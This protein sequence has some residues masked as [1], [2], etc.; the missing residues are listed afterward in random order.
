MEKKVFYFNITYRCNER[1]VFCGADSQAGSKEA[2]AYR[3]KD[4]SMQEFMKSLRDIGVSENDDIRI[5]GGEPSLHPNF[6]EI[7]AGAGESGSSVWVSTTASYFANPNH[8]GRL[9]EKHRCLFDVRLYAHRPDLHDELTRTPG[10]FSRTVKGLRNLIALRKEQQF[11]YTVGVRLLLA[12]QTLPYLAETALFAIHELKMD[13][14]CVIMLIESESTHRSSA[15][16]P[17]LRARQEIARLFRAVGE[18]RR[19]SLTGLPL[20]ILPRELALKEISGGDSGR[21]RNPKGDHDVFYYHDTLSGSKP[22]KIYNNQEE[23]YNPMPQ[24]CICCNAHNYCAGLPKWYWTEFGDT[25][26]LGFDV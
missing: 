18:N 10:S 24:S 23:L 22:K 13:S 16:F 7:I 4:L 12:R 25:E 2:A 5:S 1:C 21:A 11:S 26:S 9:D 14:V 20:C 19:L 8:L 6:L 15:F 3:V 17:M